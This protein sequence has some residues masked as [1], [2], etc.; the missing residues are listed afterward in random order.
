MAPAH[1]PIVKK[2]TAI[3]FILLFIS[4]HLIKVLHT[5]AFSSKQQIAPAAKTKMYYGKAIDQ[6]K[7]F[8]VSHCVICEFQFIKDAD[9]SI[10]ILDIDH[11]VHSNIKGSSFIVPILLFY[12]SNSY[13][14]GPPVFT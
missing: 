11:F 4:I 12:Y 7:I 8:P 5:H 3:L 14:R 10:C 13:S 9:T 1:H 6:E 2:L